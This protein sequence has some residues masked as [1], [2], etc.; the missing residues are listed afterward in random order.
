RRH[1]NNGQGEFRVPNLHIG[2]IPSLSSFWVS[3]FPYSLFL[4]N[5]LFPLLFGYR[6][7]T[8]TKARTTTTTTTMSRSSNSRSRSSRRRKMKTAKEEEEERRTMV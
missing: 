8:I 4:S 2:R 3:K 1:K 7:R 5:D 6:R